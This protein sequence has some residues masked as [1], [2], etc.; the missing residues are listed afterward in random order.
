MSR[1]ASDI[2]EMLGEQMLYREL[3]LEMTRRDLLIRYKQTVMGF[4]WAVFMPLVNTAVFSI[5]FTRVATIDAGTPYPL[6]AYSGLLAWNFFASTL[7]TS[8]TSLTGNSNLVTKVYFPRE[9][10]PFSAVLVSLVDLVVGSSVLIALMAWYRVV[11]STAI[12]LLPV[13]VLVHVTFTAA[14]A[15]FL[16]MANLLFR[17][18]KYIFE[19]AV[20]VWMFSSSV[21]YPT[22]AVVGWA[23]VLLRLNPMSAII[24][25]YRSVILFGRAPA[26]EF[27]IT[28]LSS[29]ALLT[30][31]WLVFHRTE[32]E[33][34]ERI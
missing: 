2:R 13:V 29:V 19:V 24:D 22:D 12:V 8:V 14:V 16:A 4:G 11:P 34:A 28:A 27:A 26:P 10:F 1:F 23:G 9:I 5:I 33:F 31:A 15:L 3:L 7:R 21:L 32:F 17:D 20:T 18:V 6:F 30:V 25:A